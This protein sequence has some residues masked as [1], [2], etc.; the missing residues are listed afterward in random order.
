MDLPEHLTIQSSRSYRPVPVVLG[1]EG[2]WEGGAIVREITSPIGVYLFGTLRDVMLWLLLAPNRRGQGFSAEAR[3]FRASQLAKSEAPPELAEPLTHLLSICEGEIRQ[4]DV[5]ATCLAIATWARAD[6]ALQTEI[7]FHQAAALASPDDMALSLATARLARDHGQHR[8]AETWFR[9]TIKIARLKK[10]WTTYVRAYLGLGTM[11]NRLGN[12]PAAKAVMERALNAARRWRLRQLAG[13][14]HHDLL[15][16]WVDAGDLRRA[17]DH[18]RSAELHYRAAP[19]QLLARLAGD[20][21]TLWLRIGAAR[22]A[23]P[24]FASVIPLSDDLGLRAVWSAQLVRCEALCG[25][26]DSFLPLRDSAMVAIADSPDPWRSA[27]AR[28]VLAWADL[29]LGEWEHAAEM[30]ESAL[31][32]A[33]QIGAAEV[34]AYA[35]QARADAWAHRREGAGVELLVDLPE[36]LGLARVADSMAGELLEAVAARSRPAPAGRAGTV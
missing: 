23:Y 33:Q 3:G 18:A 31:T 16:V 7:A 20:I 11:Y 4:E 35:E 25:R 28:V 1:M 21:A 8:R 6:G 2:E 19:K 13:E 32:L 15:H 24:V 27:E 14:A 22:R 29:T 12:G 36:P 10:D 26:T 5:S 9:R 34:Q 30:A 17:Y